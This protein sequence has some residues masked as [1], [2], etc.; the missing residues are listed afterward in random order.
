MTLTDNPDKLI[1]IAEKH[2]HTFTGDQWD[3]LIYL[4]NDGTIDTEEKLAEYLPARAPQSEAMEAFE[5]MLSESYDGWY[6][7]QDPDGDREHFRFVPL[8]VW[9][10]FKDNAVETIRAALKERA[11]D[12]PME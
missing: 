9:Y 12:R 11:D 3:C 6:G 2:Q 10:K 7:D 1:E 4:I 8:E 5:A